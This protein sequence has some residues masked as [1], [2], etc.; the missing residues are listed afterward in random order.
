MEFEWNKTKAKTN[1]EKHNISF[2]EATT[3]FG[4]P[5]AV[6][7]LDPDH[8]EGEIRYLTFGHTSHGKLIVVAHAVRGV[9]IRI[10][11]ARDMTRKEK[12]DYERIR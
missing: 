10:V 12:K 1:L 8:C 11:S 2:D 5:L 7:Y 4:D 3:V 9:K 6:T